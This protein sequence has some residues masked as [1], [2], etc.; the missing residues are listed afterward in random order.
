MPRETTKKKRVSFP[1]ARK[2]PDILDVQ[3]TAQLLTVST[4]TVYALFKSG[5]LPGRKIGRKW[6]TTKAAVLRWIED[7]FVPGTA[8]RALEHDD[9]D[10][11]VK[12][13]LSGKVRA[14]TR[15]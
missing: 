9:R 11:L 13:L 10:V 14:R 4:D 2:T 8:A 7:S 6:I 3:M 5:D 15:A 1:P 12:A